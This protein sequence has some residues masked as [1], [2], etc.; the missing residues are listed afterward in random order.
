MASASNSR[1]LDH[2]AAEVAAAP[3]PA[4]RTGNGM[5]F[6]PPTARLGGV[7]RARP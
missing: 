7:T 5:I 1:P 2:K 4:Q 6:L 3:R